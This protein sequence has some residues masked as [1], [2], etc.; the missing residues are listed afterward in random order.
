M[1]MVMV[2]MMTMQM[3]F[4]VVARVSMMPLT[5]TMSQL[6]SDIVSGLTLL[7]LA[8]MPLNPIP[9]PRHSSQID[10]SG[11]RAIVPIDRKLESV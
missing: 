2:L 9:T 4:V 1:V 10:V 3:V 7:R 8:P 6:C 5:L 11:I